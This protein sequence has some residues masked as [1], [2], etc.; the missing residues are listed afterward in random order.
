V[1]PCSW[2]SP[3]PS[4]PLVP[5]VGRKQWFPALLLSR[6][7]QCSPALWPVVRLHSCSP[8]PWTAV[9]LSRCRRVSPSYPWTLVLTVDLTARSWSRTL[10]GRQARL[11]WSGLVISQ[12]PKRFPPACSSTPILLPQE[13]CEHRSF[14]P[15]CAPAGLQRGNCTLALSVL[16]FAV[17]CLFTLVRTTQAVGFPGR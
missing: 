9:F 2:L 4:L 11:P 8:S 6:Q 7:L 17:W 13:C 15:A 1:P 10:W 14:L 12:V 3:A 16:Q 5:Q